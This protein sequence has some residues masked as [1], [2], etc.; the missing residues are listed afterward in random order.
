MSELRFSKGGVVGV[1]LSVPVL[2]VTSA[3]DVTFVLTSFDFVGWFW[4]LAG[5]SLLS[6]STEG[7]DDIIAD[8]FTWPSVFDSK[9]DG[10]SE[11][12]VSWNTGTTT[13]TFDEEDCK[14]ASVLVD[15]E[16]TSKGSTRIE[17]LGTR[18]ELEG[19]LDVFVVPGSLM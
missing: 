19:V 12:V 6:G 17:D 3:C 11:L 9:I 15:C 16:V 4:P 7:V 2:E 10:F 14:A 13:V 1:A 5:S 8:V 18:F